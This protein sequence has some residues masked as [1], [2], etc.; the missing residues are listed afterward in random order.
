MNSQ[1]LDDLDLHYRS[2]DISRPQ[3]FQMLP[4]TFVFKGKTLIH[5]YLTNLEVRSYAWFVD[6]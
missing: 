6:A 5:K 3:N 2:I 1:M 4:A